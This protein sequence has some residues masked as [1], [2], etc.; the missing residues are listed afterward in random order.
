MLEES[1]YAP[2]LI[3]VGH[4]VGLP[5]WCS[6]AGTLSSSPDS[7]ECLVEGRFVLTNINILIL[8]SR[9]VSLFLVVVLYFSF[10]RHSSRSMLHHYL[11]VVLPCPFFQQSLLR[12]KIAFLLHLTLWRKVGR[13]SSIGLS[14]RAR[15]WIEPGIDGKPV[16]KSLEDGTKI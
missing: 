4:L 3:C 9:L 10:E 8:L 13:V 2:P 1:F 14:R 16:L 11:L 15:N 6:E 5:P 12:S 7:L